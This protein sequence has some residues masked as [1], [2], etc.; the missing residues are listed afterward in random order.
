[1][2]NGGTILKTTN[3]GTNWDTL[4]NW[5]FYSLYSVYFTDA[6]IGYMVGVG[7]TIFKT[8]N[9]GTN[10]SGIYGNTYN[11]IQFILRMQVQVILS[12]E[13]EKVQY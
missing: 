6:N 3:D 1:M 12:V 7:G 5:N 8:T 4:S 11:F 2:V 10:W 9:G 13:T